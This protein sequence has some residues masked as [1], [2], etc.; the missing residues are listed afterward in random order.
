[1]MRYDSEFRLMLLHVTHGRLGAAAASFDVG[2]TRCKKS[3]PSSWGGGGGGRGGGWG[4][5][6]VLSPQHLNMKMDLCVHT[7]ARM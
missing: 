4:G 7:C 6:E 5:V 2:K 1:M 3:P